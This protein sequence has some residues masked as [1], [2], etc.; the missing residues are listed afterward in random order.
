[1]PTLEVIAAHTVINYL[2]NRG[3]M[4]CRLLVLHCNQSEL[5]FLLEDEKE[6]P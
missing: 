1:M 3:I 2:S 4:F 6:K 5:T